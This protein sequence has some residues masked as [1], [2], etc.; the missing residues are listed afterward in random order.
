MIERR[1]GG[2]TGVAAVQM[3]EGDEVWRAGREGR[4][5]MRLLEAAL[6]RS[7]SPLGAT[8]EDGR[9]QDLL[10]SGEIERLV[11]APAAYLVEFRDGLRAALLMI[12]GA[13]RDY[14]FAARLAG[15]ADPVS[16]QFLL[17]PTPNVTYSACL[18]AKI[19]E[20]LATG[21]AP[22]PAERTLIVC[23]ILESCL[24]SRH[25]G[26]RRLETPH[27]DVEYRAPEASHHAHK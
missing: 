16:C 12:N 19:D 26:N 6:S 21:A 9:T 24:R 11:E 27:L 25:A 20:M 10:A 5:S 17:T 18:V 7:D 13:V 22:F 4:W 8:L 2:E 14:C 1:R 3:I 23:G 15:E